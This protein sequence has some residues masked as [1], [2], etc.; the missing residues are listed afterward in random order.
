MNNKLKVLLLS[1]PFSA[2]T[3]NWANGLHQKG[4]DLTVFGLSDFDQSQYED[5]IRII[6]NKIPEKIKYRTDGSFSKI[7]YL[8]AFTGLKK[9][10]SNLKPVILHAHFASSYGLLGALTRY[11][12]LLISVWGTDVY[13]FPKKSVINK[14]ILKYNLSCADKIFST[15]RI[16]ADETKNYTK[17]EIE[18]VHFGVD[19]E[20]FKPVAE[21]LLFNKNDIVIGSIKALENKYGVIELLNAFRIL[22]QKFTSLPI[23]LLLVG[24]GSLENKIKDLVKK[25]NLEDSVVITGFIKPGEIV[26][27]YNEIDIMV[28]YSTDDSETFGVSVI[29]ASA[30]EKPVIVSDKGGLPEVVEN[31]V[32]GIVVQSNNQDLLVSNLEKLILDPDLRSRLGK[33]GR[34]RVI[35]YFSKEESLNKMIRN[36]EQVWAKFFH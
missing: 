26:K 8:S 21:K 15:S 34:E 23:K 28:A 20:R 1:D 16:M 2:H 19:T 31:N 6:S 5:G 12:P 13:N 25:Q 3:I 29:E 18:V 11:H 27:Y 24:R 33:A 7:I 22:K 17:K 30:C 36:Y 9:L 35:K 4:V 10:I 32:S 14:K